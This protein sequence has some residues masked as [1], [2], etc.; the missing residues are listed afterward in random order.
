MAAQGYV[1]EATAFE[2]QKKSEGSSWE[3]PAGACAAQRAA[4]TV[5]ARCC[6]SK[7]KAARRPPLRDCYA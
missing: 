6:P 1:P 4:R 5:R 2:R 7:T 3:G